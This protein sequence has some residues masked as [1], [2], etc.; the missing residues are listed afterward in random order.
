MG[1]ARKR[2]CAYT[3]IIGGWGRGGDREGVRGRGTEDL[4]FRFD[5]ARESAWRPEESARGR[6]VA[7]YRGTN[8]YLG[9]ISIDLD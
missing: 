8:G 7:P 4:P 2:Q 1:E 6:Q 9:T 5:P 3:V